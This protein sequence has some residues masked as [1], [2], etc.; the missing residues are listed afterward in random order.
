MRTTIQLTKSDVRIID[1]APLDVS[2]LSY[3]AEESF[4]EF[5]ELHIV[6]N[7]GQAIV[8]VRLYQ[9]SNPVALSMIG[10]AEPTKALKECEG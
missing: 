9:S 1:P 2:D 6:R 10:M 3:P 4:T 8:G 7:A 5:L